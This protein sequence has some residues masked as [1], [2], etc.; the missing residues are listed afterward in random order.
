MV[1]KSLVLSLGHSRGSN[2]ASSGDRRLWGRAGS[3]QVG[4]HGWLSGGA[5]HPWASGGTGRAL[6]FIDSPSR[7]PSN[8]LLDSP[9]K[10]RL[11]GGGGG[12]ESH[13]SLSPA[14]WT[15][16]EIQPRAGGEA[17]AHIPALSSHRVPHHS[18]ASMASSGHPHWRARS[19]E[20]HHGE[21]DTEV[22]IPLGGHIEQ[23][24]SSLSGGIVVSQ[25]GGQ[26]WLTCWVIFF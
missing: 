7:Q 2:R 21:V 25:N 19:S 3:M 11:A 23:R 1:E 13:K 16:V 5:V 9:P 17:I 12:R 15:R 26:S 6:G 20:L 10:G 14:S 22:H 4:C 18:G 8:P 24:A